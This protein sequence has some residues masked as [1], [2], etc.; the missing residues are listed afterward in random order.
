MESR[1]GSGQTSSPIR[2]HRIPVL[3]VLVTPASRMKQFA[4]ASPGLQVVVVL[5]HV[6]S[7]D[8]MLTFC[9]IRPQHDASSPAVTFWQSVTA[10]LG[11]RV[12]ESGVRGEAWQRQREAVTRREALENMA[13]CL[14][15]WDRR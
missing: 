15:I 13:Y 2:S 12:R 14:Q 1:F 8:V 11:T 6:L 5:F 10:S 7:Q 4:Q 3:L 9:G